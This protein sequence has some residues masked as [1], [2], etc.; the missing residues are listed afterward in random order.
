M[1]R[2]SVWI[3]LLLTAVFLLLAFRGVDPSGLARR[4]RTGQLLVC[5]PGP[6]HLGQHT[7]ISWPAALA[8]DLVGRGG[9]AVRPAAGRAG[10]RLRCPALLVVG[11]LSPATWNNPRSAKSTTE[12]A[13]AT[14]RAYATASACSERCSL[15]RPPRWPRRPRSAR[16][17]HPGTASPRRST[18]ARYW[19]RHRRSTA[20][21][22]QQAIRRIAA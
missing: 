6:A 8:G 15:V 21:S 1:P 20:F 14:V 5:H 4:A 19:R 17:L 13:R 2:T 3:G 10:H 16:S 9:D 22:L 12:Y 18:P 7:V 11:R